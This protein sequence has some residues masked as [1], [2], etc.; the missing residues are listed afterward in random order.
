MIYFQKKLI[1][2][3]FLKIKLNSLKSYTNCKRI[4]PTTQPVWSKELFY[5]ML[6]FNSCGDT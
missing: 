4:K 1:I 2:S 3:L 5:F 6:T